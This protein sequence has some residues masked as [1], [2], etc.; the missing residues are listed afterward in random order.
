MF[1]YFSVKT[2]IFAQ[3][4]PDKSFEFKLSER[5][6]DLG[7]NW[8]DISIFT[9]LGFNSKNSSFNNVISLNNRSLDGLIGLKFK[10]NYFSYA[11]LRIENINSDEFNL[12]IVTK[13][14]GFGFQN[15]WVMIK[16]EKGR[17]NWG[18]GKDISLALSNKAE[19]YDYI[20]IASDY[21][22]LGVRY[23]HGF[24]E[25]LYPNI[26]RFITGRGIE[27]SNEK[28]LLIGF[29]ETIVYSG[30]DR[31]IDFGYFNPVS[32]HLEV[33]LNNRLQI[34][35]NKSSNAVWQIH[36]DYL[37]LKKLRFSS[38]I[39]IDEFVLDPDL[40][41]GKE[42]GKALSSRLSYTIY[43]NENN[44]LNTNFNYIYVGTPT[45]RHQVG[46]NNFVNNNIP[47]GWNG[48]SDLK[49]YSVGLF[50]SNR[51]S[52]LCSING[53]LNLF[54]NENLLKESY[55]RYTDYIK[56]P[57]PSGKVKESFFLKTNFEWWINKSISISFLMNVSSNNETKTIA[58]VDILIFK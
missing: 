35:G 38:N 36:L 45:F 28:N 10:E 50:Y 25:K 17:E 2:I 56:G 48:G 27:W 18:A 5:L 37:I 42:H 6:Y 58:G 57:F 22:N 34:I 19:P 11:L 32:S 13:E 52:F 23:F 4:I 53:G 41:I 3:Q 14:S 46:T 43:K 49:E 12:K 7:E 55:S 8:D 15:N 30:K 21:G 44:F 54:G 47:L 20:T 39:L 51:T 29:S 24:L 40:E 9:D 1:L 26:N 33:E 16:Y 31:F